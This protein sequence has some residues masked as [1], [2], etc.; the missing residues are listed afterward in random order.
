MKKTFVF[1]MSL[2]AE[3][4]NTKFL[5][6]LMKNSCFN[7]ITWN[8][9]NSHSGTDI[10]FLTFYPLHKRNEKNGCSNFKDFDAFHIYLTLNT[11]ISLHSASF[12]IF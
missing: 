4:E 2:G 6:T 9:N 5:S 10:N 3:E 11:L 1:D 12:K 7:K 8:Q